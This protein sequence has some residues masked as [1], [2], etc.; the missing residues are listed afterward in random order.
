MDKAWRPGKRPADG[1]WENESLAS[2]LSVDWPEWPEESGRSIQHGVKRVELEEPSTND[3]DDSMEGLD[4]SSDDDSNQEDE[5][6]ES[7]EEPVNPKS[8]S[9]AR[10]PVNPKSLSMAEEPVDPKSLNMDRETQP[11]FI[12][13]ATYSGIK[14][15]VKHLEHNLNI[16]TWSK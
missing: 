4:E 12:G 13:C 9:M 3:D 8:L 7:A 6:P 2:T 16:F 15:V 10:E 5:N 14:S 11:S 1:E